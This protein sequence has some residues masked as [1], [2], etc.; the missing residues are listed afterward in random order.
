MVSQLV[1]GRRPCA[2][3]MPLSTSDHA[4]CVSS[5]GSKKRPVMFFT[6]CSRSQQS[7]NGCMLSDSNQP[8]AAT[9]PATVDEIG[10]HCQAFAATSESN[11]KLCPIL[12]FDPF[13]C[14][15][16][17]APTRSRQR[18]TVFGCHAFD[19]RLPRK[20]LLRSKAKLGYQL[21]DRLKRLL[22]LGLARHRN[23]LIQCSFLSQ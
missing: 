7:F 21:M 17:A 14:S 16:S 6:V 10:D 20:D 4:S 22:R 19:R 8:E 11:Q 18:V 15:S 1:G 5:C 12:P 13:W 2:F 23:L 9:L 3:Y